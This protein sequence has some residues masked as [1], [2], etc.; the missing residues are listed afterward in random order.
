MT[1]AS[2]TTALQG[3]IVTNLSTSVVPIANRLWDGVDQELPIDNTP[4]IKT[5]VEVTNSRS[6]SLGPNRK[7][8]RLGNVSFQIFVPKDTETN[9]LD[10]IMDALKNIFETKLLSGFTF[11]EIQ[12]SKPGTTEGWFMANMFVGFWADE[13]QAYS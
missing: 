2:I 10:A 3:H 1:L 9:E 6:A 4:F 8:R 5:K 13:I 12:T 7:I 11:D